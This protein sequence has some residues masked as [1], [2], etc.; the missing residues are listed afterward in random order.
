MSC[1]FHVSG[2]THKTEIN[3]VV[4]RTDRIGLSGGNIYTPRQLLRNNG[5]TSRACKHWAVKP[6]TT[7]AIKPWLTNVWK[8]DYP[9]AGKITTSLRNVTVRRMS[10]ENFLHGLNR[11]SVMKKTRNDKSGFQ[12]N[13][14]STAL[15]MLPVSLGLMPRK[16]ETTLPL[17]ARCAVVSHVW[18]L[19]G[20]Y[21]KGPSKCIAG[22]AHLIFHPNSRLSLTHAVPVCWR[23]LRQPFCNH[24]STALHFS[25]QF[26]VSTQELPYPRDKSSHC[27]LLNLAYFKWTHIASS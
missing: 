2:S 5:R 20:Y 23:H 17:P 6:L 8:A 11:L 27:S 12:E 13:G 16:K 15:G 7:A 4:S 25:M 9:V 21:N 24:L 10:Y 19:L 1:T 22:P 18:N 26:F 14:P 3:W